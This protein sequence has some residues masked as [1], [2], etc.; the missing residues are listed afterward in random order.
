MIKVNISV[1]Y[2]HIEIHTYVFS[3]KSACV[4]INNVNDKY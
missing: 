2:T 3:Q 4:Q 1:Q